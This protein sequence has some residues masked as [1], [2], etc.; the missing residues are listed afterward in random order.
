MG[1]WT[2]SVLVLAIS[3]AGMIAEASGLGLAALGTAVILLHSPRRTAAYL[4]VLGALVGA[5]ML[6]IYGITLTSVIA[7][8][9]L[10]ATIWGSTALHAYTARRLRHSEARFR[11][12]FESAPIAMVLADGEDI[13]RVNPAFEALLGYS[14]DEV[15]G[16][17]LATILAD[18]AAGLPATR[19]HEGAFEQRYQCRDGKAI[20]G[21]TAITTLRD[22]T[23]GEAHQVIQILDVTRPRAYLEAVRAAEERQRSLLSVMPVAVWEEDYSAVGDW[24]GSLRRDGVQDLRAHLAQHPEAVR[25]GVRLIRV[26]DVNDAAVRLINAPGKEAL[27]GSL[28]ETTVTEETRDSFV[29]QFV[30]IWEDRPSASV[31]VIGSTVD[32]RRIACE[33]QW[34]APLVAG[35]RDLSRAVVA[36]TDLTERKQA[37]AELQRRAALENLVARLST[38]F[39]N[40][41]PEETDE[42]IERALAAIGQHSGAGRSYLFRFSPDGESMTNTHEWC[43]PQVAPMKERIQDA[44]TAAFSWVCGRHC[45]PAGR[46]SC[47]GHRICLVRR[48]RRRTSSTPRASPRSSSCRCC[49][50]GVAVGFVGF[51]SLAAGREWSEG[52]ARLLGL[53]GEM[54]LSALERKA[55]GERLAALMKSKD[56]LLAAVSHELRT[57]LT[58]VLGLAQ[59]LQSADGLDP[60]ERGQLLGLIVEQSRELAHLVEDLLVASRMETGQLKVAAERISLAEQTAQTLRGLPPPPGHTVEPPAGDAVAWADGLRV[61]QILRNLLTNA[62]RY[63]G[64]HVQIGVEQQGATV[65]LVVGDDGTGIPAHEEERIFQPYER[66]HQIPGKPGSLGL[67]LSVSRRLARLMG[68]ELTY[69]RGQRQQLRAGAA[70]RRTRGGAGGGSPCRGDAPGSLP[71]RALLRRPRDPEGLTSG[72]GPPGGASAPQARQR[73]EHAIH[74]L[75]GVVVDE[76]DAEQAAPGGH[77][78]VLHDP[79]GVVV[80]APGVDAL[81]PQTAG[82]FLGGQAGHLQGEGGGPLGEA[83]GVG[84]AVE[85][86][87]GHGGHP[88]QE[89]GGQGLLV[90]P[91]GGVGG[92]Q[93]LPAGAALPQARQVVDGGGHPGQRFER[94]GAGLPFARARVRGRDHLVGLQGLQQGRPVPTAP[95]CGA[96]RTCRPSRRGSRPPGRRRPPGGAGRSGP[97]RRRPGPRR[98]APGR[99]PAAP[100]ARCPGHWRRPSPPASGCAGPAPAPGGPGPECRRP[101]RSPP[102]APPP[103]GRRPPGARG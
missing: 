30:A 89:A 6:L 28:L 19:G 103:P 36:I 57:P 62:F 11:G 33:L 70:R 49:G 48:R 44:P 15:R 71:A 37:Q 38:E 18:P 65:A 92:G 77:A 66:A 101:G 7:A 85:A 75:G 26:L 25:H 41:A 53:V 86:H 40:L 72:S 10:G 102:G 63:G 43:A 88:G 67:G 8:F 64:S 22:R 97:R 34:A 87:V 3:P 17:P 45:S 55:A 21:Q 52:D 80:A 47:P 79:D 4:S 61:R 84:K 78:Q 46:W 24:L 76:A 83:S 5:L 100:G 74:F 42:G 27:I 35:Q 2:A 59:E 58:A 98:R 99:R 54:F 1:L 50:R 68:G 69:Q 13:L 90:L 16:R 14:A 94:L 91:D 82:R 96:R 56:D 23:L 20:W 31:E 39:I 12:A 32:G 29:E 51:D 9:I 95:R 60:E 93:A 73:A 81:L